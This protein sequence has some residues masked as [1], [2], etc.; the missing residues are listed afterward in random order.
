VWADSAHRFTALGLIGFT[1]L[2]A[3]VATA[4]ITDML[5]H[6]R[7]RRNEWFAE[8]RAKSERD[9]AEARGALAAGTASEDQ[10]L[11][12]NRERSAEE[13]AQAKKNRPGVFRRTSDWLFS[14]LSKEEQKGGKLGAAAAAVEA[15]AADAGL[16]APAPGQQHDR[17]VLQAVE[18]KVKANR[19]QGERVEEVVRPSGGPLDRYA[20]SAAA[21]ILTT[22]KSWEHWMFRR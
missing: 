9:L 10:M 3:A 4:G 16:V 2:A 8:Q 20:A 11:L 19:R 21:A 1:V 18:D 7:R 13:A 12:I 5:L 22:E 15:S 14:G 6:N 17:S